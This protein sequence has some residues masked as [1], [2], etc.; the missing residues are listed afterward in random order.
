VFAAPNGR[1]A[2]ILGLGGVCA[3]VLAL[4]WLA[5]LGLAMV[6]AG[7]SLGMLPGAKHDALAPDGMPAHRATFL[8][9]AS[10][11][12]TPRPGVSPIGRRQFPHQRSEATQG[13]APAARSAVVSAQDRPVASP[14]AAPQGLLPPKAAATPRQG[15]A[16]QGRTAPPGQMKRKQPP[17]HRGR[18]SGDTRAATCTT[19]GRGSLHGSKKG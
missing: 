9:M 2:R 17:S 19:A 1:R 4:G 3:G 12:P 15:W 18:H 14:A 5:A 7:G 13:P 16:R 11:R 8:D 10:A 6:G